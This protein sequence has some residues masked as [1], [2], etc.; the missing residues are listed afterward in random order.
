MAPF[1]LW[2]NWRRMPLVAKAK[3]C[4]VREEEAWGD[5]IFFV[6]CQNICQGLHFCLLWPFPS[7]T[8]FAR[9]LWEKTG[10]VYELNKRCM[11]ND[12]LYTTGGLTERR[13]KLVAHLLRSHSSWR[14]R[15]SRA[16]F[17]RGQRLGRPLHRSRHSTHHQL[18]DFG[19]DLKVTLRTSGLSSHK[20]QLSLGSC[21]NA[22]Y[23]SISVASSSK[24]IP[25]L[26]YLCLA[27]PKKE[28]NRV[29]SCQPFLNIPRTQYYPSTPALIP[30]S[31]S[32]C[33]HLNLPDKNH[34]IQTNSFRASETVYKRRHK[35]NA[36]ETFVYSVAW[37]ETKLSWPSSRPIGHE[38]AFKTYVISLWF[39]VE[40]R[41]IVRSIKP[42][43]HSP[44]A[45]CH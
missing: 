34:V 23:F 14:L 28:K 37:H 20:Q 42:R 31:I 26:S 3:R 22:T 4:A 11:S 19:G 35:I 30:Y 6:G 36:L 40:I 1:R 24:S 44:H 32:S 43:S 38:N 17:A 45:Q 2:P 9:K 41:S 18:A 39:L 33:S 29:D 15:P 16:G 7:N 12:G 25:R 10:L 27:W 13:G 5:C 21:T 8:T